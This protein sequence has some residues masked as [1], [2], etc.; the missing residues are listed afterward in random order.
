MIYFLILIKE[1]GTLKYT[2]KHLDHLLPYAA[3]G[4]YNWKLIVYIYKLLKEKLMRRFSAININYFVIH[5]LSKTS[6][7]Y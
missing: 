5:I 3:R 2:D 4:R 1:K 6:L 7:Q